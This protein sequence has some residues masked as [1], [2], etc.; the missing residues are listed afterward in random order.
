MRKIPSFNEFQF[1]LPGIRY[2]LL[3]IKVAIVSLLSK[4]QFSA[5]KKTPVPMIFDKKS[6][7]LA[8]VGGMWLQIKKRVK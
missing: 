5:S 8:P 1:C 4:Y 2:G 6:L 3:Q 7:I